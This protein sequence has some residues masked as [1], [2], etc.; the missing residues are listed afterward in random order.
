MY[1]DNGIEA[2]DEAVE[3]DEGDW[4]PEL[5]R[6]RLGQLTFSGSINT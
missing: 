5:V 6:S 2:F 3:R 1:G 4:G